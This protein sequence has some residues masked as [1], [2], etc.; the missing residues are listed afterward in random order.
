[1]M[2]DDADPHVKEQYAM[3]QRIVRNINS[4]QQAG[5]VLPLM[6]DEVSKQPVFKFELLKNEGGKAYDTTKIKEYYS[7]AI[8]T[9]L[10]ADILRI[11]QTSTGSYALGSIKTTLSA[12]AIETKLKEICN[13]INQHLIPLLGKFNG[14]DLTRLPRVDIDDLEASSLEEIS[15]FLQRTGSIGFLPKTPDV[16]NKIMNTLGLDDLPEGTNLDEV[17]GENKSRAGDGMKTAGAGTSTDGKSIA[18][19][20]ENMDNTA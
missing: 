18:S 3:F 12:L 13:V 20:D 9:A 8:L 2:A 15:K 19:G 5:M 4:N 10:S 17:L 1:M 14:W 7:N 16:I 11:G 6:Y